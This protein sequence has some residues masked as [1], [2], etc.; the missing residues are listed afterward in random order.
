MFPCKFSSDDDIFC[1]FYVG[2]KSTF[3][4]GGKYADGG[5]FADGKEKVY[6][7][8]Y[9]DKYRPL[10]DFCDNCYLFHL[11]CIL[12]FSGGCWKIFRVA[13]SR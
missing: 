13:D 12:Y 3:K 7:Y 6:F 9:R 11:L 10:S 8:L 5:K 4:F 1:S 2:F